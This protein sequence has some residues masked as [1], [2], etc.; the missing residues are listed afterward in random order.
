MFAL[1]RLHPN[2]HYM[3]CISGGEKLEGCFA[4]RSLHAAIRETPRSQAWRVYLS[5]H[6]E[7]VEDGWKLALR[8]GVP[9]LVTPV[10]PQAR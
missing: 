4:G 8:A 6:P 7:M 1:A 2:F 10:T 9:G 5:G 3:P